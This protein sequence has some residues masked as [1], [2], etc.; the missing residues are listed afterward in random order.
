MKLLTQKIPLLIALVALLFVAASC[1][2]SGGSRKPSNVDYYTCTMHPSVKSQTPGKCPICS[3]DLVP[4]MKRGGEEAKSQASPQTQDVKSGGEMKD[5]PGMPGMKTGGETKGAQTSEFIV[6]VERQQQIGVTYAKVE[7][8]PL[9]HTI[10]A[11]GMVVPDKGRNWQF[12]SRVDGYVQK[13]NVTAPGEIVEK[14]APLMSIYSPDLLTS[15]REFVELLRMRDEAR[16]KDARETPDKLIESAKRRLHLWNVTDAQIDELQRTRKPQEN[17]TLLSPFRG[18]VQSVPVDQGKGVKVGDML[19]EV[20]DLSV[21]WVWAEF[22][23][24]ELSM[25]QVGQKIAVTAKSYPGQNFEGTLSLINP[26]LDEMKRTAKVRIDIPNPEFKLR[27]GM[28]VNA[29]LA[30]DMGEALTVPVSAIMPTGDR[31]IVFV[32]KGEGKLEPRIVRLGS[33][34]GDIYEVQ[35]GLQESERV[36][37]SANFLIDAE[38]KVQGALKEFEQQKPEEAGTPPVKP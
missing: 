17:L 2:K 28:Y 7:R 32:D 15:E 24:N 22:Y 9:R 26:F 6:P 25:L 34:Y 31:N 27:P 10:R 16:T 12:V 21:V 14:D 37:A 4:V 8:K 11:V 38:S 36:I 35:S 20:A 30:M 29:E 19:V 33:K 5:M 18:I 1:G 3:M 23:E 13:L